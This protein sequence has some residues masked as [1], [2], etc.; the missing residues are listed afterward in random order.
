MKDVTPAELAIL[1]LLWAAGSLTIRELTE[2]LYPEGGTSNYATVQKLL[3]RLGEKGCVERK[4][5]GRAFRFEASVLRDALIDHKL[6]S[7]ADQLCDGSLAPL[8]T[9]LVKGRR[10]KGKE[11]RELRGLL[12]E[13]DQKRGRRS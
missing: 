11:L 5:E 9:H 3:E 4:K 7:V 6:R 10:L 2:R 1:E 8:L 12:D 13:L